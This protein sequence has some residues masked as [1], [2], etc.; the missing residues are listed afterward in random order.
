MTSHATP[1][2]PHPKDF[3]ATVRAHWDGIVGWHHRKASTG[4]LEATNSLIQ[5]PKRKARGHRSPQRAI[6]IIYLIGGP[7]TPTRHPLHIARNPSEAPGLAY[8]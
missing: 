8:V 6:T 1:R 2:E 3:V 4:V 5:T 7:A